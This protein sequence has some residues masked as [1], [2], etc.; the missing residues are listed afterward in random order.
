M[1]LRDRLLGSARVF[2]TPKEGA[3]GGGGAAGG[4]GGGGDGAGAGGGGQ[5]YVP[6]GLP[7][8]FAG[9]NERETIDRLFGAVKGIQPGAPFRPEGLPDHLLGKSDKET[10]EKLHKAYTGARTAVGERGAVPKDVAGYKFEPDDALKPYVANFDSDPVYGKVREAALAAGITDRQFASFLPGVLKTFIDGELVA[11][12]VDAKAQLRSLAP[13]DLPATA[14][15]A[16]KEAA[17]SKRMQNNIAWV[18]GAKAQAMFPTDKDGKS[19]IAEFFAAAMA[20]DPRA[21]Q[22]VEWLRGAPQ[23]PAM[24]GQGG[25]GASAADVT[26]R[27]NDPR[28]NPNDAKFDR[29]FAAET[30]RLSKE[31]WGN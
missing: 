9:A 17:A 5:P 29:G 19:P 24:N 6:E 14:T 22:A 31:A 20:S 12:P 28:N 7:P 18:D 21:H 10:V 27:L 2:D 26:A 16:E 8:E 25:S 11:A 15:D 30:D 23:R 13:P 3:V 1:F 4:G